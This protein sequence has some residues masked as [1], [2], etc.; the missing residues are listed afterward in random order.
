MESRC[1][2]WEKH[3][4][5]QTRFALVRRV[6]VRFTQRRKQPAL[7]VQATTQTP[8][9]GFGGGSNVASSPYGYETIGGSAHLW[10]VGVNDGRPRDVIFSNDL[11]GQ[12][13][14]RDEHDY[15]TATVGD[16]HEI[17]YRFAGKQMG[18]VGNIRL[19]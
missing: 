17:W 1:F 10:A 19:R 6:G 3:R 4:L 2:R 9:R 12:A 18:Y 15:S 7:A 16:P 5:S 8:D 13:L 11:N 14:K